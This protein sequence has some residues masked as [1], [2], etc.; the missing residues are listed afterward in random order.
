MERRSLLETLK[1]LEFKPH[2]SRDNRRFVRLHG[3]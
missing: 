2:A 1:G 3:W